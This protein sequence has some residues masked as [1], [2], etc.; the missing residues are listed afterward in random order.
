MKG[1]LHLRH[2]RR[3]LALLLPEPLVEV[4]Q[5]PRLTREPLVGEL[6]IR[7]ES[8]RLRVELLLAS[9]DVAQ[10]HAELLLDLG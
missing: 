8:C 10:P 6:R 3:E 5:T 9:V 2:V 1:S 4:R 7:F